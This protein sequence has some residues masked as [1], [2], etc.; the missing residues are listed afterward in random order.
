MLWRHT[1]EMKRLQLPKNKLARLAIN[2][3]F[4][5]VWLIC[6]SVIHM[7]VGEWLYIHF[8]ALEDL[9]YIRPRV[10]NFEPLVVFFLL[11]LVPI[12]LVTRYIWWGPPKSLTNIFSNKRLWGRLKPRPRITR[13]KED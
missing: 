1:L 12:G 4:V 2:I 8:N 6:S 11:L 13:S 3:A 9:W 7:R 5:P 10:G